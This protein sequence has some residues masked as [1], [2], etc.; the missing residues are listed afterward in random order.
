MSC[1]NPDTEIFAEIRKTL[2]PKFQNAW[3]FDLKLDRGALKEVIHSY[4]KIIPT[5]QVLRVETEK[6]E[7]ST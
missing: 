1:R 5:I 6:K 4:S 3:N 2:G 7:G